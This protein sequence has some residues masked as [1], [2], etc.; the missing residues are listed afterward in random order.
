MSEPL[1]RNARPEDASTILS[2]MHATAA[3]QNVPSSVKA[4]KAELLNAIDFDEP[5]ANGPS[6]QTSYRNAKVL[7][8]EN[9]EGEVSGMATYFFTYVA[10][11]A[12]P[13]MMLEDLYV[14]PAYRRK[15]YARLLLQALAAE[16]DRLGCDRIEWLCF[17]ENHRALN[18]YRS[19]GAKEM[20][21]MT[22]IRLDRQAITNLANEGRPRN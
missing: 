17:R 12:K 6:T 10:W 7:L 22:F 19:L 9:P 1:I 15:G 2:F 3:D 5:P 20:E 8:I 21:S 14:Q 11:L 13:G 4:T 16:A 18:F